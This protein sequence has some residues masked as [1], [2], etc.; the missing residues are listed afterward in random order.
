MFLSCKSY[1]YWYQGIPKIQLNKVT[2]LENKGSNAQP[3]LLHGWFLQT[4][5]LFQEI[6]LNKYI[7]SISSKNI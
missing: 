2:S 5:K 6:K 1:R 7:I 3:V 4:I